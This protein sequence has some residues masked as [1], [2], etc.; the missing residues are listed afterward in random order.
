MNN[1]SLNRLKF[2]KN[3]IRDNNFNI[4]GKCE[5]YSRAI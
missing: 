1:F 3:S 4:Y 5:I 2:L